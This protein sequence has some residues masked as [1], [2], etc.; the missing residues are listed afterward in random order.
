[1]KRFL[2]LLLSLA[3]AL[4]LT[5]CGGQDKTPKDVDINQ[6]AADMLEA[7]A[8]MGETMEL[9]DATAA[10][11]Y[12]MDDFVKEYKVYISTMYIAEEVAVFRLTD[13]DKKKDGEKMVEA[14]ISDLKAGFDNYLPEEFQ[15]VSQNSLVLSSGDIVC[16]LVGYQPGLDAAKAVFDK[17]MA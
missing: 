14:R 1:M 5:A 16:Y 6:L 11:Y 10:N 17:A 13:A 12:D 3:L 2:T 15:T 4:S 9:S 7:L 8:P